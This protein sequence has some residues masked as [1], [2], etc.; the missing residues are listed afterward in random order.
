[1]YSLPWPA[2]HAVIANNMKAWTASKRKDFC[3]ISSLLMLHGNHRWQ[4]IIILELRFRSQLPCDM[5]HSLIKEKEGEFSPGKFQGHLKPFLP[6][7]AHIHCSHFLSAK[8]YHGAKLLPESKPEQISPPRTG[9]FI[10][11][12]EASRA[13]K[14]QEIEFTT[15]HSGLDTAV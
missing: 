5:C 9:T 14:R 8:V 13:W 6:G 3:S 2:D 10:S 1:M 11:H 12:K 7:S 4:L 15:K